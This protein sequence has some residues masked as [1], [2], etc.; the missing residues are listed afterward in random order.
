MDSLKINLGSGPR[1]VSGF[2]NYDG[3]IGAVLSK[4]PGLIKFLKVLRIQDTSAPDWDPRVKYALANK[5][6]HEDNSV[7]AIYVSHLLEHVHYEK[8]LLILEE[9]RRILKPSGI[10]RICSPDYDQFYKKF[11][12]DRKTD[13]LKAF[14]SWEIALLSHPLDPPNWI[15]KLRNMLG[16]HTHLW[17]PTPGVLIALLKNSGFDLIKEYEFRVGAFP[18]LSE[19]EFR[20]EFSCYI[21]AVKAC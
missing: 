16:K 19:I 2:V 13:E 18:N 1:Y 17:H 8:A 4:I 3:S 15:Q 9:V 6:S 11:Q 14:I 20:D 21:E 5:L 10:L 7:D 12:L